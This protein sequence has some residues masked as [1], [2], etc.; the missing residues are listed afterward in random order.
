MA[1]FIPTNPRQDPLHV[2]RVVSF[3]EGQ[4]GESGVLA[5]LRVSSNKEGEGAIAA[6]I[7]RLTWSINTHNSS[8]IHQ[9]HQNTHKGLEVGDVA[10]TKQPWGIGPRDDIWEGRK[11]SFVRHNDVLARIQA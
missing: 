3:G 5:P 9:P 8:W 2:V 7:R 6:T 10:Y 1:F 11:F 4:V